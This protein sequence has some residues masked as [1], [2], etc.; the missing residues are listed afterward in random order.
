MT[1]IGRTYNMNILDYIY[2]KMD[3]NDYDIETFCIH[4]TFIIDEIMCLIHS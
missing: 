3:L 4:T 2:S 1:Y